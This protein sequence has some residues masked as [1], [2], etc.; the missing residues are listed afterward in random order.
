MG[1]MSRFAVVSVVGIAVL[2]AILYEMSETPAKEERAE[3]APVVSSPA[4]EE[5]TEGAD[6]V[7]EEVTETEEA[8]SEEVVVHEPESLF[9]ESRVPK[10]TL[11]EESEKKEQTEERKKEVVKEGPKER[12]YTVRKGDTLYSIAR[13]VYG[14]GKM[15]AAIWKANKGVIEEPSRLAAGI[16]LR[17]PEP[18]EKEEESKYE[19]YIVQ[20]GDTLSKISRLHYGTSR[21][22]NLI[23]EANRDRIKEPER[24][25]VGMLIRIPPL[26]ESKER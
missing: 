10:P 16:R 4:R 5:V 13:R 1:L 15:W 6:A 14:D 26:P 8:V 3:A 23:F 20:K 9:G 19:T 12:F 11:A 25:R 22:V 24:L 21:F 18:G 7:V 2:L 17:L